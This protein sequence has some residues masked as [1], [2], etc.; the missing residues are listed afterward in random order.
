MNTLSVSLK[1]FS[2]VIALV[3]LNVAAQPPP[4]EKPSGGATTPATAVGAQVSSGSVAARRTPKVAL[5]GAVVE[6]ARS[7][8]WQ[9]I[10]P[11]APGRFTDAYNNVSFDPVTGRGEGIRLFTISF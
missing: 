8:P 9:L 4:A 10:N 3:T 7:S 11:R 6:A 5:S 1:T 2:A